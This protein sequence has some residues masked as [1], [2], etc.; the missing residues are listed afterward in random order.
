MSGTRR[1]VI[2]YASD[3][4]E[5][6]WMTAARW[7]VAGLVKSNG[8][9]TAMV[10]GTSWDSVRARARTRMH[11]SYGEQA[12][13]AVIWNM[14]APAVAEYFGHHQVVITQTFTPGD[15]G[16]VTLKAPQQAG[17]AA[18]RRLHRE[19]VTAIAIRS[20]RDSGRRG[21]A[22]FQM[23]ELLASMTRRDK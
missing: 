13:A 6:I 17:Q 7:D 18:I 16:W 22:D 11:R 3:G 14:T 9:W 2:A 19:G 1:Q 23:D 8:T 20:R 21:D 4:S 10:A 12:E 5:V 15:A